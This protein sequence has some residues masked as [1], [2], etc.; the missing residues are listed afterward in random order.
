M[1]R[2][3]VRGYEKETGGGNGK[4]HGKDKSEKGNH[5]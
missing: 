1:R 3:V 5:N 4:G 2:G